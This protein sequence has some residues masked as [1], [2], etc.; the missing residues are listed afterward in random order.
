VETV[1]PLR[2]ASAGKRGPLVQSLWFDYDE[3]AL[4]C[5]TQRDSVLAK[6]IHR[7]GNVGWEVSR[8]EPPYRGV[9]GTGTARIVDEIAQSTQVLER[10][11][12]RYGQAGTQL[13]NWLLGRVETEVV[14]RIDD[15]RV[16]SWDYAPRM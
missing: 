16:T 12:A 9:R 5:A 15:L 6:R 14:V 1:V 8:D 7:D 3:G 10:L 13:A 2:L 11:V 4:W